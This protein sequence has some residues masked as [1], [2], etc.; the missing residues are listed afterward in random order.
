MG[1]YCKDWLRYMPNPLKLLDTQLMLLCFFSVFI[2]LMCGCSVG[3]F[4][5]ILSWVLSWRTG[6]GEWG[7][8]PGMCCY[9]A[10]SYFSW[11]SISTCVSSGSLVL[12]GIL[13][14]SHPLIAEETMV[15]RYLAT[16]QPHTTGRWHSWKENP[17][18]LTTGMLFSWEVNLA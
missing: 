13:S 14:F 4:T 15:Q 9:F 5:W 10:H 18:L 7:F 17:D 8:C 11:R 6:S 16:C 12:E 3:L 1:I 2:L